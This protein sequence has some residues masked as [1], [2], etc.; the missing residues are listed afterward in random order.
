[1]FCHQCEQTSKGSGCTTIGV[2]E[3]NEDIQSLQDILLFGS[4]GMAAYAY[5]ARGLEARDEEE[6]F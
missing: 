3:K 4:K 6:Q 1:M 2:C 5:H